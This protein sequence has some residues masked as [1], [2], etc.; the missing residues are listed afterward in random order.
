MLQYLFSSNTSPSKKK[1]GLGWGLGLFVDGGG[2]VDGAGFAVLDGGGVG[3][4][5]DG[6]EGWFLLVE[7]GDVVVAGPGDGDGDVMATSEAFEDEVYWIIWGRGGGRCCFWGIV[8]GGG[9]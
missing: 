8:F 1:G 7:D 5:I 9:E 2:E 6:E 3:G 4:G